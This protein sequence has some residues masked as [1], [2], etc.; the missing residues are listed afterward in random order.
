MAVPLPAAATCREKNRSVEPRK[1]VHMLNV[2]GAVEAVFFIKMG[3]GERQQARAQYC[4]Q[5]LRIH[6]ALYSEKRSRQIRAG[7]FHA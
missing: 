7:V 4:L 2:A 5:V 1:P 3:D 6:D